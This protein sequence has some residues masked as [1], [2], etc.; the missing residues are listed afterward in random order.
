MNMVVGVTEAPGK[1]P[2]MKELQMGGVGLDSLRRSPADG[3]IEPAAPPLQAP[4]WVNGWIP[5]GE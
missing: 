1:L 3:L 2:P 4:S 5:V